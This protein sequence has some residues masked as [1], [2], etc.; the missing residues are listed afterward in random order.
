VWHGFFRGGRG[1]GGVSRG[2]APRVRSRPS[3]SAA[4]GRRQC[5]RFPPGLPGA[6]AADGP[7]GAEAEKSEGEGGGF[8][9]CTRV[10][11]GEAEPPSFGETSTIRL[12]CVE[13]KEIPLAVRILIQPGGEAEQIARART[14]SGEAVAVLVQ[15]GPEGAAGERAAR[16]ERPG[17][18]VV[19][20]PIQ[21]AARSTGY[22][23]EKPLRST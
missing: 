13:H 17:G 10:V 12:D 19:E 2:Y 15:P 20:D 18:V 11:D 3:L 16:R 1:G 23:W 6:A 8:G 21:A 5:P 7:E 14:G 22:V 9:N 4:A